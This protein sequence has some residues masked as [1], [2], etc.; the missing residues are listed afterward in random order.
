[1]SLAPELERD[2]LLAF[3]T[4]HDFWHALGDDDVDWLME[5]ASWRYIGAGLGRS[6]LCARLR[7]R[8]G[9][10]KEQCRS[11]G[12]SSTLKLSDRGWA[13]ACVPA[14]RPQMT[15]EG[16]DSCV[17]LVS[18]AELGEGVHAACV[19]G[20]APREAW[21]GGIEVDL[22]RA[23]ERLGEEGPRSMD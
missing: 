21:E 2:A 1:M 13:L 9:Y 19:M 5:L 20:P 17:V 18:V 8:I 14:E 3:D 12:I 16:V 6:G 11:I 15:T 22:A 4:A 10:T 7:E 23:L